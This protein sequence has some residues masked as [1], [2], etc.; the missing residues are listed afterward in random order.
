[1]ASTSYTVSS[2][3]LQMKFFSNCGYSLELKFLF[4]PDCGTAT[5][6]KSASH[7]SSA[8]SCL[9]ASNDARS[10][11]TLPSFSLPSS[12]ALKPEK[13]RTGKVHSQTE[14]QIKREELKIEMLLSKL[15]LWRTTR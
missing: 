3:S 1:M 5:E 13:K 2:V 12:R 8:S 6:R 14:V 9:N 7:S 4:C 11:N 10:R 15:G